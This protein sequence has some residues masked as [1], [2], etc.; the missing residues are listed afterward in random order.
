[1]RYFHMC[2]GALRIQS[3]KAPIHPMGVVG[4][5]QGPKPR[6]TLSLGLFISQR[7]QTQ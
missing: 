4:S 6:R 1:M 3:V 7:L 5:V 2:D